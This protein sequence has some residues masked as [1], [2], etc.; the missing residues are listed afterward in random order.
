MS[1]KTILEKIYLTKPFRFIDTEVNAKINNKLNKF[2]QPVNSA[3]AANERSIA[4]VR[5]TVAEIKAAL[6]SAAV[7]N[8]HSLQEIRN[9]LQDYKAE[10]FYHS[11]HHCLY[12]GFVEALTKI[13]GDTHK[14]L[15]RQ[16]HLLLFE[17]CKSYLS[18]SGAWQ[19]EHEI[20]SFTHS[21]TVSAPISACPPALE[22]SPRLKI[23]FVSGMFPCIE[24]GG[25]LRLFDIVSLLSETHDIDLF[26]MFIPELDSYSEGLLQGKFS[27]TKLVAYEDFNSVTLLGWLASLGR[28]TGYYDVIQCEYPLSSILMESV[29]PYGRKIGF[30]FMECAAKSLLIKL[31]NSL[32]ERDFPNMG[33]LGRLFWE[34]TVAEHKAARNADFVIAVTEEDAQFIERVNGV[35]PEVIPTCLSPSQV[36][37]KIEACKEMRPV[38]ATVAFLGYFD[39]YPN[40][41][42][43]KWY[44]NNIHSEVKKRVAGYR[45][46]V[47]GTGNVLPLREIS[48]DDP[49]VSYTG[50]VDDIIPYILQAKVCVLPLITGAGIRG[51]LTQYSIAGRPSVSTTIG[52]LGLNFVD[53]E[54]VLIADS[55]HDFAEAV[56]RLLS[57][58]QFNQSIARKAKAYA[59][60]NFTWGKYIERLVE[61]YRT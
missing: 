51:K 35:K 36:I 7:E 24:H 43:V 49:T 25:G 32:S 5:G 46:L 40:I 29:R 50:R 16:A 6:E 17:I 59:L 52:N 26:S 2:F 4:E 15:L 22:T 54:N 27:N 19:L 14:D 21:S 39:H 3:I 56:I 55:P 11:L 45:F 20:S 9:L 33:R 58:E 23:L 41:D 38:E 47:I 13:S 30:T 53:G 61:I 60:A 42:G 18:P 37:N 57:D 31:Q 48:G 34:H 10:S 1:I 8:R 44:L 28:Q 12:P